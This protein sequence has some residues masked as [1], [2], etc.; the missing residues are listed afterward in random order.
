MTQ[1]VL[2]YTLCNEVVFMSADNVPPTILLCSTAHLQT[3]PQT[4][5]D[6]TAGAAAAH[7]AF[8]ELHLPPVASESSVTLGGGGEFIIIAPLC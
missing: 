8:H 3:I 2:L 5:A 6:T 7:I 1:A 4:N